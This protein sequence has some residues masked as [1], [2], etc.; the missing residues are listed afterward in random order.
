MLRIRNLRAWQAGALQV[1][2]FRRLWVAQ[3][4]ST[5]G[6]QIFPIAATVAVLDAGG[7]AADLGLILGSR[8]L[9][10]VL[11]ALV[12]GVWAD[13]LPRRVVMMGADLFRA[14]AV[15]VIAA[16]PEGPPL[17]VLAVA[18]FAVGA[19]EAFFRPAL[20]ALIPSLVPPERLAQANGL[21]SISYRSAA[22]IGP[23]L[24]GILVVG[25]GSAALAF[26]A[27]A[28]AFG[29]SMAFLRGVEEPRTPAVPPSGRHGF[30]REVAEGI[31]EVRRHRW[32]AGTLVAASLLLM[33]AVAPTTV[34]LPVI[35]RREFGSDAVFAL[36]QVAFSL[37]GLVG[38]LVAMAYRP[39]HVGSFGWL[40]SLLYLAVPVAL[41]AGAPPPVIYAAFAVGGFS[42][43][44]FAV[45]W[46]SA[47]QQEIPAERLARVSSIDWMASFGLMPLGLAL[48]GPVTARIGEDAVLTMAALAI[49]T[50]TLAVL[51]VPGVRDFRD[52]QVAAGRR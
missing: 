4:A 7:S 15:G 47:L 21:V 50:L 5:I 13:R 39:R 22:V 33:L 36:A 3:A 2:G 17:P 23:G 34:L 35:G 6:D 30:L 32:V 12:G 1:R 37:G 24:G 49:L 31:A 38:A 9:A 40:I 14:V 29:I 46:A 41:L 48:T 20:T 52:P 51:S 25:L 28:V 18:V 11:F 8:W 45:Y 16:W 42:W 19:G 26:A 44:P 27:N 43:E 10:V